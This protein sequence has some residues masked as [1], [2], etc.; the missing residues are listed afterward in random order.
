VTGPTTLRPRRRSQALE[1]AIR[2]EGMALDNSSRVDKNPEAPA[3]EMRRAQR[4]LH[5]LRIA[6]RPSGA[7][8]RLSGC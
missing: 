5:E 6:W 3:R 1:D 4:E 7:D 8:G 2:M